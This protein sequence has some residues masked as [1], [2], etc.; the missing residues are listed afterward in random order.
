MCDAAHSNASGGCSGTVAASETP[1]QDHAVP[2]PLSGKIGDPYPHFQGKL[3]LISC[4]K[5][6]IPV[7]PA[8][9]VLCQLK[10]SM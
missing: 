1:E 3:F 4:L 2:K 10:A 7:I 8:T 6:D 5:Y 9:S